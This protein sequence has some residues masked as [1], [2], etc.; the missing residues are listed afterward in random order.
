MKLFFAAGGLLK[1]EW[2]HWPVSLS[3][4]LLTFGLIL[5]ISYFAY[6][7]WRGTVWPSIA[8]RS[9]IIGLA[10]SCALLAAWSAH[11]YIDWYGQVAA[12]VKQHNATGQM[13]ETVQMPD[14][15]YQPIDPPLV[16]NTDPN[17][18]NP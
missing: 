14:W 17:R 15:W 6:R 12:Q 1:A 8:A 7:F 18:Y 2:L 13:T 9:G 4:G 10:L 5:T 11:C 16:I 3:L